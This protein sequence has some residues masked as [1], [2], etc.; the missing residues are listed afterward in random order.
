VRG[1]RSASAR[2][3]S[4]ALVLLA[5]SV[6]CVPAQS[7]SGAPAQAPKLTDLNL[8]YAYY[9]PTSLVPRRMGWVEEAFKAQGTT[10]R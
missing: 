3:G 4:D 9:S 5:V 10:V 6:G 1:V 2:P 8:D 7:N